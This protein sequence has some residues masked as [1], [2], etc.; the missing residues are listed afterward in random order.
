MQLG[1]SD[2][3]FFAGGEEPTAADFMMIFPL[4][5]WARMFPESLG[6]N[7]REYVERIHERCEYQTHPSP[8]HRSDDNTR[9]AFKR[10]RVIPDSFG[11]LR[12]A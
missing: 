9:P 5:L 1:K 4:E 8:S 7:C 2:G 3:G 10:V 6:P 12:V 11:P